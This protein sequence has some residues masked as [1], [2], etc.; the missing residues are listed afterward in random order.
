MSTLWK[1]LSY[2]TKES[3]WKK[4]LTM[5]RIDSPWWRKTFFSKM[6]DTIRH[7]RP[8][9][10]QI[11][12]I[13]SRPIP[14]SEKFILMG[15]S[16]GQFSEMSMTKKISWWFPSWWWWNFW[17][18]W[19]SPDSMKISWWW[20]FPCQILMSFWWSNCSKSKHSPCSISD[21]KTSIFRHQDVPTRIFHFSYV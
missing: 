18:W 21:L 11:F 8:S 2:L 19:P 13:I 5:R 15:I 4:Y 3:I 14:D 20:K 17:W 16:L 7:L 6:T 12:I 1:S 9:G 10:D